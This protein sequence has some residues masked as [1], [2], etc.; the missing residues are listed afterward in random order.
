MTYYENQEPT[1]DDF[2]DQTA[3]QITAEV[4]ITVPSQ[5]IVA[6]EIARQII[7]SRNYSDR[8]KMDLMVCERFAELL[9]Q[10][11][12]AVATPIILEAMTRPM[13]PTDQWGNPVGEPTTLAGVISKR[14]GDWVS[15]NVDR[16]GKPAKLNHYN[17]SDVRPRGEYLIRNIVNNELKV[18]VDK[19]V[20]KIVAGLKAKATSG[21]AASVAEKISSLI[22][23]K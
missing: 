3:K 8:S 16:E 19:E 6:R 4:T 7:E 9:D 18:A 22:F 13:Q 21:I 2:I 11:I 12:E 15:D 1:D 14:I 20:S 23:T 10:K 5:E 17:S